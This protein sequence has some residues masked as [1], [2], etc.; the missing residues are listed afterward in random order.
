MSK[1]EEN[2]RLQ[3]RVLELEQNVTK[4]EK[5]EQQKTEGCDTCI[6]YIKRMKRLEF[7]V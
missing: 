1:T 5:A 4:L 2:K 3:A 7:D 6:E